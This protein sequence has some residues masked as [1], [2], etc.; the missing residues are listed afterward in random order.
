MRNLAIVLV[1]AVAATAFAGIEEYNVGISENNEGNFLTPG[2]GTWSDIAR[3]NIPGGDNWLGANVTSAAKAPYGA[4]DGT[5]A[6][7]GFVGVYKGATGDTVNCTYTFTA[8]EAITDQ[9]WRVKAFISRP[10]GKASRLRF[11]VNGTWVASSDYFCSDDGVA[12]TVYAGPGNSA[13]CF[14]GT[15][16]D[17]V[18]D[19][20][21]LGIQ[22][23]DTVV[24]KF[25]MSGFDDFDG[26]GPL[27]NKQMGL[28]VQ[29]TPE[30]ATLALLGLGGLAFIRRRK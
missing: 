27:A 30:P 22:A 19:L 16:V 24:Y 14:D 18:A 28:G 25:E 3:S 17:Y 12:G 15:E 10:T 4:S 7:E 21:G 29:L 2:P 26:G 1:L 13:Y 8:P 5:V 6:A 23:G 11:Y 20:S 9:A